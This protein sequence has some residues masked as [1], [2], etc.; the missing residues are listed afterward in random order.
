M[1]RVGPFTTAPQ[2]VERKDHLVDMMVKPQRAGVRSYQFWG[3]PTLNDAY[4]DPQGVGGNSLV[5][6]AGAEAMFQVRRDRQYRSP[7]ITRRRWSWYSENLRNMARV[8]FDPDDFVDPATSLPPDSQQTF[9]RVQERVQTT[10]AGAA[11]ATGFIDVSA[12]VVGVD[13]VTIMGVVFSAVPVPNPVLFQFDGTVGSLI[14]TIMEPTTVQPALLAAVP[15]GVTVTATA[16]P[17]ASQVLLTASVPDLIGNTITLA[18]AGGITVSGPTLTGGGSLYMTVL[19]PVNFGDPILGPIYIVPT[20]VFFGTVIPALTFQGTAPANTLCVG[21]AV[22]VIHE[23][24]Q[25]PN[26]MH[27]ILPRTT[28]S[29]TITNLSAGDTL[30]I[31]AGIGMTLR[32]VGSDDDPAVIFGAFKEIIVAGDGAVAVPFA[33]DAVVALGAGG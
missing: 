30:L 21:G 6:G 20:P 11:A 32:S 7:S 13:T 16:G 4:G 8:A 28:S 18:A 29:I 31:S 17:G 12:V 22:P 14:T 27:I 19:G 33:I 23:D 5:G 25:E 24:S 26:P 15:V 3:A 1:S 2:L 10:G 9:I